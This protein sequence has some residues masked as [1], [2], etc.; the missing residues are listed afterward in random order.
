M[1][2]HVSSELRKPLDEIAQTAWV[3]KHKG[4]EDTVLMERYC[5]SILSETKR[6]SESVDS[7]LAIVEQEAQRA[8]ASASKT[9]DWV[10]VGLK[11]RS[12]A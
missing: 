9:L 7:M 3:I 6:L 1:L 10:S 8:Q 5:D 2:T 12:A 11:R 4:A